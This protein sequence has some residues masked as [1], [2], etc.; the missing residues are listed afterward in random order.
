MSHSL[1]TPFGI[2]YGSYMLKL[3]S[4]YALHDCRI[5]TLVC[6]SLLNVHFINNVYLQLASLTKIT[7]DDKITG[8]ET[9]PLYQALG[10]LNKWRKSWPRSP[11]C[12]LNLDCSLKNNSLMQT[13][14]GSTLR[15]MEPFLLL[16]TLLFL[17]TVFSSRSGIFFYPLGSP[18]S[19]SSLRNRF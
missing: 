3:V 2:T 10:I 15:G 6:I 5:I 12:N 14:F 17:I 1:I 9:F 13:S 16:G 8:Q 18:R 11:N 19:F 4:H 7:A